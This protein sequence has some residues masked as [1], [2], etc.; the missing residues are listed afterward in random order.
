[1]P[2]TLSARETATNIEDMLEQQVDYR[3]AR[4]VDLGITSVLIRSNVP[5][6]SGYRYFSRL[7]EPRPGERAP[8]EL[9]CVDLNH[10]HSLDEA[11]VEAHA[12]TSFRGKR[13]SGGFYLT[14]HFGAPA[15]LITRGNRHYIVGH[16]LD[17]I[18]WGWYTKY[19]LTVHS[20]SV[21]SLHLKAAC[22]AIDGEGTL[23]I[24]R[25]SGGK[26]VLLTQFCQDGATFISNTH[27]IIDHKQIAHGVPT[28][29]RVRD[30]ACFGALTRSGQLEPHLDQGEYIADPELL[31]ACSA[32]SARVRNICI[33]DYRPEEGSVIRPLGSEE[34]YDM[35]EQFG[36]P[37]N[38]YGMKDDVLEF[39]HGD[40]GEFLTV[41]ANAKRQLRELV[42][43]SRCLYVNS[44][45]L[46]LKERAR[47]RE[48]LQD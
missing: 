16:N 8:Y 32:S 34:T 38:T 25:G 24:G 36:F 44:D 27:S 29:L 2:T 26:T 48:A 3:E 20:F 35:F 31:F 41:Y 19:I 28:T 37:I 7:H 4:V 46:N 15:S 45:M 6:F 30:D 10:G 43:V 9:Y 1:M 40:T 33:V 23:L 14:Y 39:C 18:I 12:D 11:V 21:G 13:F 5:K 47:L 22:F 17:R 42:N